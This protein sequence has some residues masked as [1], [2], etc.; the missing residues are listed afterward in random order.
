[1]VTYDIPVSDALAE[2]LEP[3]SCVDLQLKLP[4]PLEVNLPFGDR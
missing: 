3:I 1:M 4:K 2:A